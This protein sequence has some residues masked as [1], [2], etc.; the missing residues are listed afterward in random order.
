MVFGWEAVLAECVKTQCHIE[1]QE[2]DEVIQAERTRRRGPPLKTG[3]EK[4]VTHQKS[5]LVQAIVQKGRQSHGRFFL[6]RGL[7]GTKSVPHKK[8]VFPEA[9]LN[10]DDVQMTEERNEYW[11]EEEQ[12]ALERPLQREDESPKKGKRSTSARA[13]G[14]SP[15]RAERSEPVSAPYKRDATRYK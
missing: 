3:I 6:A 10:E 7:R 11:V 15:K 2:S 14:V 5:K 13:L 8:G 1:Y 12:R 4:V 9:L